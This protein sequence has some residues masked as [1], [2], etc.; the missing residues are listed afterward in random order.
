[1]TN[2][3]AKGNA[4]EVQVARELEKAGAIVGSRRHI[5]GAGDL[6][7]VWPD[8]GPNLIECKTAKDSPYENFR[9][10]DRQAMRDERDR[11]GGPL[12]LWLAWRKVGTREIRWAPERD[13]PEGREAA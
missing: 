7:A 8:L 5:G 10:D 11:F 2:T 6:I 4:F 13:W 1:M 12:S 9:P 3:A